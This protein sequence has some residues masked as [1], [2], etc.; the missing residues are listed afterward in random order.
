[1]SLAKRD[2]ISINDLSDGEIEAIFDVA[3]S[4]EEPLRRR[5]ARDICPDRIMATLFFEPSTRTRLSFESAMH[6]LGGSVISMADANSPG[7][8]GRDDRRHR[9]RRSTLRRY[10]RHPQP[11]GWLGAPG[12][13]FAE[14]PVI[15]AGDGAHEHPTQT[16]C[17]LHHPQE[18]GSIA[19]K[20]VAL[21]GDLRYGYRPPRFRPGALRG[22]HHLCGAPGLEM[23][24]HVRHRLIRH[25]DCRAEFTSLTR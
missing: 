12:G 10:H 19:G 24:D 17:D 9:A 7:G 14:V 18:L 13:E 11:A 4:L 20:S 25:Y 1:M 5:Q 8:Q 2:L 21:C 22:A 3:D 6:R 23:P 15:N 16:L